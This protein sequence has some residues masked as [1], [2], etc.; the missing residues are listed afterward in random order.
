VLATVVSGLDFFFDLRR[1]IQR[2][3]ESSER[4]S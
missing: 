4:L 2:G 3:Q 1:R